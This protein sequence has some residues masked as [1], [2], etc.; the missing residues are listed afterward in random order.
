MFFRHILNDFHKK[1]KFH[2]HAFRIQKI[3][4]TELGNFETEIHSLL[5]L[6]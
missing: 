2:L 5:D 4:F 3:H 6:R 1:K